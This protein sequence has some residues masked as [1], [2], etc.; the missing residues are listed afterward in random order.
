M[1]I[2]IFNQN[3]LAQENSTSTTRMPLN[4]GAGGVPELTEKVSYTVSPSKPKDGDLVEIQAEMFG[5][6]VKDAVFIWK[7]NGKEYQKGQ[8]VSR[9]S[10]YMSKEM[11]VSLSIVTV[12]G[13]PI[14]KEWVFNPENVII[15]WETNTYT[16]PFYK[17]KSL[18]TPESKLILHAINLD[19][20]N[21]L[22]NIYAN[23]V[24]KINGKVKG[25]NSGVAKNTY[26]YQGDILQ[27]EPLFE[28]L[29]TSVTNYQN[30][31]KTQPVNTRS[32]LKV[33]TH[34]TDI[35]TYEKSPLLG[36][37]FNRKISDSFLFDKKESA[38]VAYPTYFSVDSSLSPQYTWFINNDVVKT[39]SNF[40]TFKKIQDNQ[41]SLLDIRIK[42]PKAL[43]Q[44]KNTTYTIDTNTEKSSAQT[45]EQGFGQ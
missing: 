37:L 24:W 19:A 14:Y 40:L 3:L 4:G 18:Y 30:T 26:I 12:K 39:N 22:T 25:N 28:L 41:K 15:F 38:F 33:Q 10:F 9:I 6:P 20:K 27:Q 13:T 11:Q 21:P 2:Q 36:V 29:Y 45:S 44:T 43:L 7:I 1:S 32:V 31:N 34:Q 8:G 16:Q 5:T 35:F 23:Y 42:N 17:G